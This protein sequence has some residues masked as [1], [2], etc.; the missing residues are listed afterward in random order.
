M[1]LRSTLLTTITLSA[2]FAASPAN[3][4]DF[5]SPGP[6]HTVTAEP[7]VL[8]SGTPLLIRTN[9]RVSARKE[10]RGTLYDASFAEDVVDQKWKLLIP[11]GS[12]AELEVRSLPYYGPGGVMSELTIGVRRITVNGLAYPVATKTGTPDSAGHVA[13]NDAP[14][15]VGG[16]DAAGQFPTAGHRI[17][18]P[19][20]VVLSFRIA[21][22]IGLQG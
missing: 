4:A 2:C 11:K 9:D 15:V 3:R 1:K 10:A 6:V 19:A 22:P 20:N 17:N 8:P 16:G 21:D 5:I 7:G 18:L 13:D 12:S 14:R